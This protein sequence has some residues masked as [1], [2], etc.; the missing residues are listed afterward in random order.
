MEGDATMKRGTA[1]D[2]IRGSEIVNPRTR[3]KLSGL[4]PFSAAWN[5]N[6]N[7]S[8]LGCSC[9]DIICTRVC[10]G[11]AAPTLELGRN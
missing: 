8:V 10:L 9:N 5:S 4:S 3:I 6:F 2:V 1:A 11:A 7:H